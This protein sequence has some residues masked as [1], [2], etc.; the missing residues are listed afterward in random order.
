MSM[1][2]KW[3]CWDGDS[4]IVSAIADTKEAAIEEYADSYLSSELESETETREFG[5]TVAEGKPVLIANHLPSL[6]DLIEGIDQ[7]ASDNCGME[8]ELVTMSKE[9]IQFAEEA[10]ER[11]LHDFAKTYL[12]QRDWSTFEFGEEII[13]SFMN[14]E[15]TGWRSAKSMTEE[16]KK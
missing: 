11:M 9:E 7:S 16:P 14:G 12:K 4:D 3:G 1:G 15:Y 2:E 8:D 5:A 13:I 6:T 10:Y